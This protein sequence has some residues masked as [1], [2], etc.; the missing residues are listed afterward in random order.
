[1][2]NP[3]YE[4]TQPTAL[5][6]VSDS[7]NHAVNNVTNEGDVVYPDFGKKPSSLVKAADKLD[8]INDVL[9]QT[10]ADLLA[11]VSIILAV[12]NNAAETQL[13]TG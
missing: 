1:M 11:Q 3:S 12:S 4:I 5:D 13:K 2:N 9:E 6:A 7:V 10:A 8:E